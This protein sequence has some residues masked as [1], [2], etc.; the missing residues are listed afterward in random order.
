M[1]KKSLHRNLLEAWTWIHPH[2]S[3]IDINLSEKWKMLVSIHSHRKRMTFRNIRHRENMLDIYGVIDIVSFLLHAGIHHPNYGYI[4]RMFWNWKRFLFAQ[5]PDLA[6]RSIIW[7][8]VRKKNLSSY[9]ISLF[10]PQPSKGWTNC[11]NDVNI[12]I[13]LNAKLVWLYPFFREKRLQSW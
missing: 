2:G 3:R 11:D 1:A 10:I 7:V 6:I 12:F 13:L 4:Y 8:R 9:L 5:D